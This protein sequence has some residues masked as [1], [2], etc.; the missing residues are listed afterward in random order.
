MGHTGVD[1]G[2]YGAGRWGHWAPQILMTSVVATVG[3]TLAPLPSS[4]AVVTAMPVLLVA[5]VLLTWVQMHRHD[6]ALCELC[7]A[8]LPL[9]PSQAARTYERRLAVAHLGSNRRGLIGYV[10][11]LL[12]ADLSVVL[13]PPV[14]VNASVVVWI[15]V[16]STLIYVVLSHVTHRRLQPWCARCSGGGGSRGVGAPDPLPVDSSPR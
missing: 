7:V 1:V 5:V 14:W 15:C 8:A 12:G 2:G 9:N 6:R 4:S 10:V 13:V 3:L 16:Q 11:V